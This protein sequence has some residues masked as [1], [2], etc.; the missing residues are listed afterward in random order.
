MPHRSQPCVFF[1]H[2]PTLLLYRIPPSFAREIFT[3]FYCFFTLSYNRSVLSVSPKKPPSPHGLSVLCPARE[4]G[5][6]YVL[7]FLSHQSLGDFLRALP[8]LHVD[9][10]TLV[11]PNLTINLT[12]ILR[13]LKH[14]SRLDISCLSVCISLCIYNLRPFQYY[15]SRKRHKNNTM[16]SVSQ[17][18]LFL[19]YHQT[20]LV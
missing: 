2:V 13:I 3:R 11:L 14:P 5:C 16:I 10:I 1:S 7:L 4:G 18:P 12:I 8:K 17:T 9:I 19:F 15:P 6:L 20:S